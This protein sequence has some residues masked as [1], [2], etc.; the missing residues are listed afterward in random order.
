MLFKIAFTVVALAAIY[1]LSTPHANAYP[2][3]CPQILLNGGSTAVFDQCE[4]NRATAGL[5]KGSPNPFPQC[6]G[7]P[8]ASQAM[9]GDNIMAGRSPGYR[10]PLPAPPPAAPVPPPA[11]PAPLMPMPPGSGVAPPA[12]TPPP[13]NNSDCNDPAYRAHYNLSCAFFAPSP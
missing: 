1:G 8:S 10:P 2:D 4:E 6:A 12:E 5:P 11:S 9:C 7:L 13:N 3:D